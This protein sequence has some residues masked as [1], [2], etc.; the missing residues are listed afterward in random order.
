MRPVMAAIILIAVMASF[1]CIPP[2]IS[3]LVNPQ[4]AHEEGATAAAPKD[5][6]I[7]FLSGLG[8]RYDGTPYNQMGFAHIRRQLARAGLSFQDEHFLKFSYTGGEVHGGRWYPNP[9]APRDTGRP[10]E[11]SV[12]HL[13]DM[14]RELRRYHPRARFLLVGY[15]LGGRIAFDYV[16]RYH[17]EDTEPIKGVITLNSPL[18][19]LPYA[20]IDALAVFHPMW[21]SDAVKQLVN[22]YELQDEFLKIKM[23]AARRLTARGVHLATFGTRQDVIVNPLAACPSD[24]SGRPMAEGGIISVNPFTGNIEGLFGHRQI[25]NQKQVADYIISVYN[26]Q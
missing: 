6:Y 25:L 5:T 8:T 22:E 9:Y 13:K 2:Q 23:D 15:S 10:I 24:K 14:I 20:G 12:L 21:G 19:G 16:I 3:P 26:R 18:S 4:P 1:Y 17:L 7:V 11:F